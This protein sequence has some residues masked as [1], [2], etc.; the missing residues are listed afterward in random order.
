M[1]DQ[2]PGN[3]ILAHVKNLEQAKQLHLDTLASLT[4]KREKIQSEL[5]F[6]VRERDMMK[7]VASQR[8]IDTRQANHETLKHE[9]HARLNLTKLQQVQ[10]RCA[11]L[12]QRRNDMSHH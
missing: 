9:T 11:H 6:L 4:K 1:A 12:E 8:D 10:D 7:I 5:D 3:D 2:A